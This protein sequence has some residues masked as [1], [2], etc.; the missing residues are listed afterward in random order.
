M[1]AVGGVVDFALPATLRSGDK[2]KFTVTGGT[3]QVYTATANA[4]VDTVVAAINADATMNT[5]VVGSRNGAGHLFLTT[6]N[7]TKTITGKFASKSATDIP[8]VTVPLQGAIAGNVEIELPNLG[9]TDVLSFQLKNGSADFGQ[10]FYIEIEDHTSVTDIIAT[11]ADD[12]RMSASVQASE[13]AGKLVLTAADVTKGVEGS[14]QDNQ[15]GQP[16]DFIAKYPGSLGN[17]L[18]VHILDTFS[19]GVSPYAP[20]FDSA[21]SGTEVHVI[22]A[23]DG[24]VLEKYDFL[25]I[26]EGTRKIDGSK[27]Y[28]VDVLN[29]MSAYIYITNPT[30]ACSVLLRGGSLGATFA[31]YGAIPD[32]MTIT[33]PP[34][35]L[36]RSLYPATGNGVRIVIIDENNYTVQTANIKTALDNQIGG[37]AGSGQPGFD[38]VSIVV[39]EGPYIREVH[40]G[41]VKDWRSPDYYVSRFN[42]T[43]QYADLLDV[44]SPTATYPINFTNPALLDFTL[45]GATRDLHPQ[46]FPSYEFVAIDAFEA[47]KDFETYDYRIIIQGAHPNFVGNH[48]VALAEERKFCAAYV[49]PQY[50]SVKQ[51]GTRALAKVVADR[52]KMYSVS[53]GYMDSNWALVYDRYNKTQFWMPMN[54]ITALLNAN[55]EA[56]REPWYVGYG[57]NYGKSLALFVW[58][59]NKTNKFVINCTKPNQPSDNFQK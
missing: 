43:C 35:P 6:V 44:D 12:A 7:D 53:Y 1:V 25:N 32:P 2:I 37:G 3:E 49:S 59:G 24:E 41:Y 27:A 57:F 18:E 17:G 11:I 15:P 22:I 30:G 28:Y 33:A 51:G 9:P 5:L 55:V 34:M 38:G 40:T 58:L 14:F 47:M 54:P 48:I 46:N 13:S 19:F 29:E 21:P 45:T 26:I 23:K 10:T 56:D 20:L 16:V 50:D 52:Q 36:A 31:T 42:A 39:F 4:T 8:G